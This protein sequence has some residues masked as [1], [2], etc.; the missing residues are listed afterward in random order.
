MANHPFLTSFNFLLLLHLMWRNASLLSL[1][2]VS[3]IETRRRLALLRQ[4]R[5]SGFRRRV[6]PVGFGTY[7]YSFVFGVFK[8]IVWKGRSFDG[9]S[10][11]IKGVVHYP[12]SE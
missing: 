11:Y 12:D 10:S 5:Q 6:L 8:N 4:I 3:C 7:P 1:F 9:E 2:L